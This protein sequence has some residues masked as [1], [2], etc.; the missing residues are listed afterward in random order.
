MAKPDYKEYT[1]IDSTAYNM[2]LVPKL[3]ARKQIVEEKNELIKT[4][5]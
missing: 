1:C 4:A 3:G 2:K 5:C